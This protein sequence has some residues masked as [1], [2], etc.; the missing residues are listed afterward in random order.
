MSYS[1]VDGA[2]RFKGDIATIDGINELEELANEALAEFLETGVAD[3]GLAEEIKM[4][5]DGDERLSYLKPLFEGQ[6][7]FIL[8]NGVTEDEG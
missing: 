1:V 6:A 4:E 5:V 2:G 7:P 3:E 8:T